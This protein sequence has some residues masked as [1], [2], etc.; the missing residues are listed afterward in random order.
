MSS[1]ATTSAKAAD[2]A[3]TSCMSWSRPSWRE[4]TATTTRKITTIMPVVL[5][6][7]LTRE[8]LSFGS[9]VGVSFAGSGGLSDSGCSGAAGHPCSY[10][11]FTGEDE[12]MARARAT[13][14]T[15][16]RRRSL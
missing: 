4:N 2:S 10:R 8:R 7:M 11:Q 3:T 13:V 14:Q 9:L 15:G 5:T 12:S 6:S 16:P 1:T